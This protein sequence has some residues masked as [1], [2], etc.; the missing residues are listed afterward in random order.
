MPGP[1]ILRAATSRALCEVALNELTDP[2]VLE[3]QDSYAKYRLTPTCAEIARKAHK[4][5][6]TS[7]PARNKANSSSGSC[8][9]C[10]QCSSGIAAFDSDHRQFSRAEA[11]TAETGAYSW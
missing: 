2:V 7:S 1:K 6:E 11:I 10:G 5:S 8:I 4:V 3:E 9:S